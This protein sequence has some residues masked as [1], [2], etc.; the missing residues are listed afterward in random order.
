MTFNKLH[1]YLL[2]NF[3][4][5]VVLLVGVADSAT[6]AT[7]GEVYEK[8][9]N[10]IVQGNFFIFEGNLFVVIHV[11]TNKGSN[12]ENLFRKMELTAF[13]QILPRFAHN[14]YPDV[15]KNWFELYS[16][17]PSFSSFTLKKSFV[18]DKNKTGRNA[19]LVLTA[20]VKEI[21]PYIP[22]S[23]VVKD[24][25]NR[26]FDNDVPINLQKFISVA[27]GN[28]LRLAKN[29]LNALIKSNS[30]KKKDSAEGTTINDGKGSDNNE[31]L[32]NKDI[33]R[34]QGNEIEDLL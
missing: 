15:D 26:A 10:E 20:P 3:V 32:K 9:R 31:L 8:H 25:V 29:K 16:L 19:Y 33:L 2:F 22:E 24:A 34:Q 28:R 12:R 30:T 14:Q 21:K 27:S 1:S 6:G 11:E 7:P 4:C 5:S 17:L 18:V 23:K 13:N